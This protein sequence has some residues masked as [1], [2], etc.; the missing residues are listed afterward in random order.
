MPSPFKEVGQVNTTKTLDQKQSLDTGIPDVLTCANPGY[1]FN[2][3]NIGEENASTRFR[4]WTKRMVLALA[5][6]GSLD[7]HIA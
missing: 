4:V 6:Q 5:A 1:F 2:P 3:M 7:F